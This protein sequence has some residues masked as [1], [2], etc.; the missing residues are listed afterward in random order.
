MGCKKLPYYQ[1]YLYKEKIFPFLKVVYNKH[2]KEINTYRY[3][4]QWDLIHDPESVLFSWLEDEEEGAYT[5]TPVNKQYALLF[6]H[7]YDNNNIGS[8]NYLKAIEDAITK[9]NSDTLSLVYTTDEAKKW[10]KEEKKWIDQWK[11]R[12]ANSDDVFN[13]IIKSIKETGKDQK[14]SKI[15]LRPKHIYIG[16]YKYED[17]EYPVAIYGNGDKTVMTKAFTKIQVADAEELEDK[18]KKEHIYCDE[19]YTKYLVIAFYEDEKDDPSMIMQV[20]KFDISQMQNTK[21]KWLEYLGI[22]YKEQ[23]TT[24]TT[25]I[26]VDA[27]WIGQFSSEINGRACHWCGGLGKCCNG[28]TSCSKCPNDDSKECC[29]VECTDTTLVTNCDSCKSGN[30]CDTKLCK[31]NNCCYQTSLAMI[32]KYNVTTNRSQSMD[33][34]TL[35]SNTEWKLQSDLQ[36]NTSLFKTSLSYIDTT[37]RGGKPIVIGVHYSNDKNGTYNSN[38]ATFHFMVIVGKIH[39]DGKAYYR[40][41]DPGRTSE[42]NGKAKTNLLEIDMTKEMIHGS[43][44]NKTYTVTEVRKNL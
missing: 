23:T 14:I 29:N 24:D 34:A 27:T 26:I 9:G 10:T 17:V 22:L 15:V 1:K 41:Y 42:T 31:S 39:K 40:F 11:I 44:N 19:T 7:V 33:I 6:N 30:I 12:S 4:Y 13:D 2:L 3:K 8:M 36:A 21:E 38:K 16:K 28:G 18:E 32:E 35:I 5:W 37:L 20:E 25:D 43:Y